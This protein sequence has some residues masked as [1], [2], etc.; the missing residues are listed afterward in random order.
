M[1]ESGSVEEGRATR[2]AR[3]RAAP[4]LRVEGF[5]RGYLALTGLTFGLIVL[6]ALVRAHEAGLACP[7]WPLCFGQLIPQIDLKVALF[8]KQRALLICGR[9]ADVI[10]E[11]ERLRRKESEHGVHDINS[12]LALLTSEEALDVEAH[13][14]HA[15][16]L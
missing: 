8:R 6:G 13:D 4:G 11:G 2:D 15:C 1:L 3:P 16:G 7:D 14:D 12:P 10:F 9:L 5:A